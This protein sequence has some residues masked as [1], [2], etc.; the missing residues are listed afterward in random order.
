MWRKWRILGNGLICLIY[1]WDLV[2]SFSVRGKLILKSMA[3]SRSSGGSNHHPYK[4]P[5]KT[6]LQKDCLKTL[7]S[8]L[9]QIGSTRSYPRH[10]LWYHDNENKALFVQRGSSPKGKIS[11]TTCN[12]CI[13]IY[14]SAGPRA[15]AIRRRGSRGASPGWRIGQPSGGCP[16]IIQNRV[17]RTIIAQERDNADSKP[18]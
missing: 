3:G 5:I 6:S 8:K 10:Q 16:W 15:G 7:W 9:N 1:E 2:N 14:A 4:R 13:I 17:S 12:R 11:T 18:G